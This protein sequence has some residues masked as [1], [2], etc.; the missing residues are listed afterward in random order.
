VAQPSVEGGAAGRP[1]GEPGPSRSRSVRRARLTTRRLIGVDRSGP[2]PPETLAGGPLRP[3]TV[4]NAIGYGRV[5][6]IV[7]FVVSAIQD[8]GRQ[9]VDALAA[10]AFFVAGAADYWDGL[11]ARITGQYSRLGTLLDPVIDRV[12]VVSGVVVCW[13]YEL[14][15][16]WALAVLLG[17]EV[18]VLVMGRIWLTRRL[19]L[20]IN[21]PGR[22]AVG[23]TMLGVFF[24]LIGDRG[25]GKGWLYAGLA[26][27]LVATVQYFRSGMAQLR[28]RRSAPADVRGEPPPNGA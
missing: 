2:P 22:L 3:W 15:P 10:A 20:Q 24:G 7:V 27:A 1:A 21:W 19:E 25:L 16:R 9:G 18:F 8:G 11:A 4:P 12:L 14:L 26:L 28:E 6:L 5:V 17:R 13:S 23:P